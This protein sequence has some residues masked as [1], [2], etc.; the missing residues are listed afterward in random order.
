MDGIVRTSAYLGSLVQYETEVTGGKRVKV[1]A[2]NPRKRAI[3]AEG[4]RVHL[5][6]ESEDIVPI[7]L[8][9]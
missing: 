3:F 2:T 7:L 1:N 9:E 6:F 5:S 8:K 4:E